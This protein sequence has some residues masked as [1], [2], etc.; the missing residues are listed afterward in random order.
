[1][2]ILLIILLGIIS[3]SAFG[4]T[5]K[6]RTKI[7]PTV[8]GPISYKNDLYFLGTTGNLYQSNKEISKARN[9]FHTDQSS[10][11]DL[12]LDKDTIYFG[13]GLHDAKKT[14]LYHFSLSKKK[15]I[16][17]IPLVGHIQRPVSF[18]NK[19]IFVGHGPG[20]VSAI[21]KNDYT[22]AWNLTKIKKK[23]IHVDSQI[24][25]F[26]NNAC[27]NSI[28][29]TKAFICVNKKTGKVISKHDFKESPKM[30]LS[31]VG[32]YIIGA[33]TEANLLKS[34]FDIPSTL[35]FFN[36]KTMKVGHTQVLRG[37]NFFAPKKINNDEFF[38]TLSTGDLL[39]YS[40]KNKKITF[41]GEY[42]EPFISTPFMM[43]KDLCAIGI[44]G[45]L[46][47]N[48]KGKT[49][50]QI[51]KQKRYFESP[52]GVIR[53]IDGKYYIPSRIGYLIL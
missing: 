42:P 17:K 16:K 23:K 10:V 40:I 28:Y 34:K 26:A 44:M 45:Q 4:D 29:E 35:F 9:I 39:T 18:D 41:V 53:E 7:G 27:F 14:H 31:V 8:H 36:M 30:S 32:D 38:I 3:F 1:M 15:L 43:G 5:K 19:M 37:F 2:K 49:R 46:L 12:S 6:I 21:N 22:I 51:T 52:I 11:S 24:I 33:T 48:E 50:Y 20:G 47:C 13:D 25:L